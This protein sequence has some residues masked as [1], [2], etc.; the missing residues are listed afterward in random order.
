MGK[1]LV[2]YPKAGHPVACARCGRWLTAL[3]VHWRGRLLG[4]YC[5]MAEGYQP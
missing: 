3:V 4:F 2:L 1:G 5:A